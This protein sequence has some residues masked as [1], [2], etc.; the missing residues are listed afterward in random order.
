MNHGGED[1]SLQVTVTVPG[2]EQFV[3]PPVAEFQLLLPHNAAAAPP[4]TIAPQATQET[5]PQAT[6][7]APAP[8]TLSAPV[9]QGQEPAAEQAPVL[10]APAPLPLANLGAA[11]S[12]TTGAGQDTAPAVP[13]RLVPLVVDQDLVDGRLE[14]IEWAASDATTR[15][16]SA[17]GLIRYRIGTLNTEE[18]TAE[19][20]VA[21]LLATGGQGGGQP[22]RVLH[23]RGAAFGDDSDAPNIVL[24]LLGRAAGLT[25]SSGL[26]PGADLVLV[27][28][29]GAVLTS[30]ML[31][32]YGFARLGD[33]VLWH[34][35]APELI[36][37]ME[38]IPRPENL[39][40]RLCE[41]AQ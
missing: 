27:E 14:V 11:P 35:T 22:P 4:Q 33:S 30:E 10:P 25:L 18:L 29:N 32:E 6:A 41:S 17:L 40:V 24:M 8:Q 36:A 2:P 12:R 31:T 34:H 15:S 28:T 38:G 19:S 3:V 1:T 16:G 37:R 26:V 13:A 5:A 21:P 39:V 7:P 23:L 9:S 20:P